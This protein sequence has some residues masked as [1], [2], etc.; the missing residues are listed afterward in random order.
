[1]DYLGGMG[2]GKGYIAPPPPPFQII[3]GGAGPQLPTLMILHQARSK[4]N[5]ADVDIDERLVLYQ[6]EN[7]RHDHLSF[8]RK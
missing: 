5:F 8:K 2:G 4:Q 7:L 3:G 6:G 1:M